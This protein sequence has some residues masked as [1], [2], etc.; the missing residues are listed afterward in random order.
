MS[1]LMWTSPI[2]MPD[3][4]YSLFNQFLVV[5][6]DAREPWGE[7]QGVSDLMWTSLIEMPDTSYFINTATTVL[8]FILEQC[9]LFI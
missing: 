5:S 6:E 1:D 4:S 7:G 8:L 3:T 9:L 2:K